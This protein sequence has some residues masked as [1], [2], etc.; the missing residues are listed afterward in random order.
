MGNINSNF[1][2]MW[3]TGCLLLELLPWP[4]H[5]LLRGYKKQCPT[6]ITL[7]LNPQ[8]TGEVQEF[9]LGCWHR[10]LPEIQ[11]P[12]ELQQKGAQGPVVVQLHR[13][14]GGLGSDL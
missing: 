14:E 3:R 5:N 8:M 10:I 1:Q 4:C 13:G 11:M 9:V 7:D 6:R 2:K 12:Q